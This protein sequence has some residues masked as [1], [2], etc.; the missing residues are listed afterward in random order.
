MGRPDNLRDVESHID[1]DSS[2]DLTWV[3]VLKW[4]AITYACILVVLIGLCLRCPSLF[5]TGLLSFLSLRGLK[6]P[7]YAYSPGTGYF[8]KP[9][10]IE[11]VA[12][13]PFKHHEQ[14]SIL[15]CYLQVRSVLIPASM[16]R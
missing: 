4:F 8:D 6:A 10:G 3:A 11:I 9:A 12:L 13:V 5:E 16:A 15:D 2:D 1:E 7:F 14:T